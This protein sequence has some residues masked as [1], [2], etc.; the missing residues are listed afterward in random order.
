M[1]MIIKILGL[2]LLISIVVIVLFAL[3]NLTNRKYKRL[4]EEAL[5]NEMDS[6]EIITTED[7]EVLPELVQNYLN[8]VG[9]V[10]TEKVSNFSVQFDGEFKMERDSKFVPYKAEQTS[11]QNQ[12]IRLFYMDLYLNKIKISGLHHFDQDDA[13]MKIKILDVF[14]VVNEHGEEMKQAE[15]VTFFNDMVLLAPQTLISDQ[16]SWK[17]IDDHSVEATFSHEG[18]TIKAILTF[19]EMGRISNFVSYDRLA[20]EKD[21]LK[22]SVPWSTPISEYQELNGFNLPKYGEAIW[23][24]EDED[25]TY[26]TLNVRDIDYNIHNKR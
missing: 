17:E 16:I 12:G 23:H 10:G 26:I 14:T 25:F 2:I 11:F 5:A 24:Y 20:L 22:T 18:V 3:L 9:V 4:T 19:D 8:Y 7:L 21:G 15:T 1:K 6:K 13:R